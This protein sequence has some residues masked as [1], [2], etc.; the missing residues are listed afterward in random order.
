MIIDIRTH[1]KDILYGNG[2]V[3]IWKRGV[4]SPGNDR[5]SMFGDMLFRVGREGRRM[6]LKWKATRRLN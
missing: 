3:S 4:R 1:L 5:I 2:G 6:N